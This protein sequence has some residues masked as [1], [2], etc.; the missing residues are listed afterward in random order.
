VIEIPIAED[1]RGGFGIRLSLVRDHQFVNLG[2]VFVPWDDKELK[3]EF[4]AFATGSVR[5]PRPGA[6]R[7]RRPRRRRSR[8]RTA[9]LLV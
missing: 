9:E 3:V 2:S 8:A 5:A 7:C 4:A 1:S 6:S